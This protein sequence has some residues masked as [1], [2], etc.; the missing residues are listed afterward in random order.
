MKVSTMNRQLSLILLSLFT[1]PVS[2]GAT[3]YYVLAGGTGNHKGGDWANAN[4]QIPTLAAGDIVFIGNSSGNL[5]DTK[6][7]CAGE[8]SHTFSAG[9]TPTAHIVIKAAIASDHGTDTGWNARYG[10][11]VTPGILWDNGTLPTDGS[12]PSIWHF[13]GSY[14]DIDGKVGTTD[15]TRTYGFYFRNRGRAPFIEINSHSCHEAALTD[16]TFRNIELDGV[17]PAMATVLGSGKVNTSG[18]K[19]T[20]VSDA[21][22]SPRS[23]FD[24][25]GYWLH[26]AITINKIVYQGASGIISIDSPTTLTIGGAGAGNKVGVDYSVS[27]SGAAGFYVGSNVSNTAT[28]RNVSVIYSYIHD[29]QFPLMSSGNVIGLTVSHDWVGPN[30]SNAA[31]HSN[32]V[33]TQHPTGGV[34]LDNLT[35]SESVFRNIQGT[36]VFTCLAG[37]CDGWKIYN[38]TVYYTSDWD[39]TCEHLGD[40][41]ATCGISK[42]GGDNTVGRSQSN[43][44][45]T[46]SVFYGNTIAGIHLKPGHLG[47]DSAAIGIT[48]QD[49]DKDVVGNNLWYDCTIGGAY[50]DGSHEHAALVSHD[51]N[52]LLNTGYPVTAMVLAAHEAQIGAVGQRIAGSAKDPFLSY[53]TADFRLAGETRDRHLNQGVNLPEPYDRDFVGN[54]RGADGTWEVGAFEFATG[55]RTDQPPNLPVTGVH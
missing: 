20:W 38:N 17:D 30:Y 49:S 51:Y 8:S 32:G 40:T 54:I 42:L 55:R 50:F 24:T 34:G 6:T 11:D 3:T 15:K 46:N 12:Q 9:G 39:S 23:Q 36:G 28:V 21:S 16:L 2:S 18:N 44:Q 33:S 29:Q 53:S 10:V 52:T 43:N 22:G 27:T 47:A 14:Y 7:A 1:L 37:P 19:I 5:A 45:L 48:A 13:C 25:S 31:K 35:V 4:C 26:L 41:S